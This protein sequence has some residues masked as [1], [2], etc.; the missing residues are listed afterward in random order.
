MSESG[1]SN[2]AEG[3]ACLEGA[4]PSEGLRAELLGL[5]K[6]TSSAQEALWTVLGPSLQSSLGSEVEERLGDFCRKHGVRETELA[7]ALRAARFLFRE[8]ARLDLDRA[9]FSG[10][11]D[12]LAGDRAEPLKQLLLAR[13]DEAIRAIQLEVVTGTVLDHGRLLSGTD[14]RIDV[15]SD[16]QRGRGLKTPVAM[17]TF[18]YREGGREERFTMQALPGEI[19]ALRDVC[20]QILKPLPGGESDE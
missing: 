15:I 3:L 1:R 8:A 6:L 18:R 20:N 19:A 2:R 13:Y 9:S 10:D 16:S 17:L 5:L 12:A 4:P 7:L 11:L 14:W